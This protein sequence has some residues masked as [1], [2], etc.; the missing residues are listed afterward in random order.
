MVPTFEG[1]KR[2]P[3]RARTRPVSCINT[4]EVQVNLYGRIHPKPAPHAGG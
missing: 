4:I 2:A 3:R 1:P